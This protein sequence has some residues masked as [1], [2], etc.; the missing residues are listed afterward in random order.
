[1]HFGLDYKIENLQRA[2]DQTKDIVKLADN[3]GGLLTS[4][5]EKI[6]LVE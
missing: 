3:F 1:L 4:Q 6:D 5:G 2:K